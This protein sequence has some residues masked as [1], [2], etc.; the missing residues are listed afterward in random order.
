VTADCRVD[1]RFAVGQ[2]FPETPPAAAYPG[3]LARGIGLVDLFELGPTVFAPV[4]V[5]AGLG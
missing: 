5:V 3:W 2:F 4:P 1:F